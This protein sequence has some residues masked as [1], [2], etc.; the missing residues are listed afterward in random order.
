MRASSPRFS[1]TRT[2]GLT[3]SVSCEGSAFYVCAFYK[4][5]AAILV[6]VLFLSSL[7]YSVALSGQA[8]VADSL[9]HAFEGEKDS[10]KKLD[11]YY[12]L[13]LEAKEQDLSVALLYADTLEKMAKSARNGKGEARA[14]SLRAS[15]LHEQGDADGAIALY[16]KVLVMYQKL[17]DV[18]GQG[19]AFNGLGF[20]FAEK[21]ESDSAMVYYLKAAEAK[22]KTGKLSDVASV[23]SNIGN[24]YVDQLA[25]DKGIEFLK[26][27]LKIRMELGEDKR[28]IYTYNNLAVAY[29]SKG[30]IEPAMEYAQKGIALAMKQG[31][32]FVAGVI[33]GG[34]GHLLNEKED[35]EEAIRWC[36]QSARLLRE[37][38]RPANLVFPLVNMATAYNGLGKPAKALAVAQEGY[39]IM[40]E[41]QQVQP[42]E[43]YYEEMAKAYEKMG[44]YE[45][46]HFW[47]KKFMVLD[48]SLFKADNVANIAEM[49]TRYETKKKEAEISAQ[50]LKLS[51]QQ[52]RLFRQRTWI[53]S[54]ALGMLALTVLGYLFY[55]RYRLQKKAELDAAIIREQKLGLNAVIEAQEAE[56][57]RIAKDLHDGIAQELVAL[58]MGFHALQR[59]LDKALPEE[60]EQLEGLSQQLDQSCTEVRNLSHVM[61]PPTLGQ[62]GLAPSLELLLRNSLHPVG[63]QTEFEYF[64]LPETLDEKI[65]V[66]IYRIAQELLNNILKHAGAGK[67]ALQLYLASGNL[68]LKIEDDGNS[69]DFESARK[70]GSMG[71][72]NILSRV[73]NLEGTFFSE[74]GAPRGT[75]STVRI[76]V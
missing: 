34:I 68:V 60:S 58:K 31:N 67:V 15:T 37:A 17:E 50:Q 76:P 42:L 44:N 54:L 61:L 70:A 16:R 47:F 12:E 52:R 6:V 36:E 29:G 20:S 1:L 25:Y 11:L 74:P 41:T 72:L 40:L 38:N 45:Q 22:E 26:K 39:A 62:H 71:L 53:F 21:Q 3:D 2:G 46:A 14:L 13:A 63:I 30:D 43:V 32:K 33:S 19:V 18:E 35:Y 73:A 49:E 65:E 10:A 64:G 23:Y 57:R 51:E 55:N 59:K 75:V 56:R 4:A 7:L 66:G 28:I 5:F 8:T 48:D 9:R 27:A 24:L 69:F